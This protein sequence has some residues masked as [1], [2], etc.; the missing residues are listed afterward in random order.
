MLYASILSVNNGAGRIT[1][2]ASADGDVLLDFAMNP[3]LFYGTAY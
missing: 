2:S 1:F 3:T